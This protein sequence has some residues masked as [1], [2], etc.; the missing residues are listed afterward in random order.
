MKRLTLIGC[1]VALAAIVCVNA[2]HVATTLHGSD[3]SIAD[4]E[5]MAYYEG[6][7]GSSGSSNWLEWV[8]IPASTS[9]YEYGYPFNKTEK[10]YSQVCLVSFTKNNCDRVGAIRSV[11]IEIGPLN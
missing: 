2:W 8:D 9:I 6:M 1:F 10:E 3:L 4:V 7:G 5:A 11:S